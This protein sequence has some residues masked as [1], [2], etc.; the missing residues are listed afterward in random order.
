MQEHAKARSL[1]Q[2]ALALRRT[3]RDREGEAETLYQLARVDAAT[4]DYVLAR[5][6]MEQVL[7]I[8]ESVRATIENQELRA[9]YLATVR[10]YYEFYVDVLMQLHRRE[11]SAG[12]D[13]QALQATEMASARTLRETLAN[14]HRQVRQGITPEGRKRETELQQR[15]NAKAEYQRKLVSNKA[16]LELLNNAAQEIQALTAALQETRTAMQTGNSRYAALAQSQPL[17][18]Q[19]M[20]ESLLDDHTR[21]LVYSLGEVR[22]YLWVVSPSSV[23]SYELPHRARIEAAARRAYEL[24]LPPLSDTAALH[25]SLTALHQMIVAPINDQ[26]GENRLLVV[27]DG[28]L[29]YVPFAALPDAENIPLIVKHEIINLPSVNSLAVL[30]R[31][32]SARAPAPKTIAV[33]ADP[34]F[35]HDDARLRKGKTNGKQMSTSADLEQALRDVGEDGPLRRLLFTRR[36]AEA[37]TQLVTKQEAKTALDFSA[38][39]TN[40]LSATLRDYRVLHFATH[41]ILNSTHPELSGLV[42]SLVDAR[43]QAQDGFFRLHEIYNLQLNAELVVLS[44]CQTGLGKEIKGEGL[45]GLTRGFMYAGVPR[46]IAS[47]WKVND[48]ATAELMKHFYQAHFGSSKLSAAA[49]LRSAQLALRAQ[50]RWAHPGYWAAFTLQGEWK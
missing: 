10:A 47:L 31:E 50:N 5:Q 41:G 30:R 44:A 27:A 46:V 14:T 3:T 22:S 6:T 4:R 33:F 13:R 49:A 43:G 28:A 24:L 36:E 18:V 45:I 15:L 48:K 11:P 16:S 23:S 38:S 25:Q 12:H 37:I 40:A 7:A 42:L 34:V 8:T 1:L 39:R 35:T 29:Q 21:L 26:L 2:Q 20:Q 19:V 32:F 9:T 17:S